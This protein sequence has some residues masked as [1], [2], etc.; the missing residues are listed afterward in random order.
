MHTGVNKAP[1]TGGDG[2]VVKKGPG[3][4][5]NKADWFVTATPYVLPRGLAGPAEL[6][7]SAGFVNSSQ[8]PKNAGSVDSLNIGKV[9]GSS[10]LI[11]QR[12]KG[13]ANVGKL[14]GCGR[15]IEGS[16]LHQKIEH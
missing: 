2:I 4:Q 13:V 11:V 9:I 6:I 16:M 10:P 15:G 7:G 8:N 5:R 12:S 14:D 1:I 3:V